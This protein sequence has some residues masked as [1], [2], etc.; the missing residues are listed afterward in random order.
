MHETNAHTMH[1]LMQRKFQLSIENC[2]RKSKI[3]TKSLNLK[4]DRL[5][6]Y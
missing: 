4:S 6:T 2:P 3:F 5:K 1:E